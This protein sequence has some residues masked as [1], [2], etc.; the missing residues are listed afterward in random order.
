MQEH[1]LIVH[2][3]CQMPGVDVT[4]AQ[5]LIAEIGPTAAAHS[6]PMLRKFRKLVEQ[7][8]RAG[9]DPQPAP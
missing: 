8:R 2:R 9:I 1:A 6:P 5:Q 4:A 3:L 7:L